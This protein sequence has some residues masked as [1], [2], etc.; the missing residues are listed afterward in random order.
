MA[1]CQRDGSSERQSVKEDSNQVADP[2]DAEIEIT[3]EP[4]KID[5]KPVNQDEPNPFAEDY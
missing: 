5:A 2:K 4:S 3:E 1:A